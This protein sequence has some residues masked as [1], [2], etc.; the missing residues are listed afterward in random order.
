MSSLNA[1]RI[2]Q[3]VTWATTF[4]SAIPL[5]GDGSM[6][7]LGLCLSL[8]A[9]LA[10]PALAQA[11]GQETLLPDQQSR[12]TDSLIRGMQERIERIDSAGSIRK[13]E[14]E[15][16]NESINKAIQ[17][18]SSDYEDNVI[19]QQRTIELQGEINYLFSTQNELESNLRDA[20]SKREATVTKLG[21]EISDLTELLAHERNQTES[22]RLE[23]GKLSDQS[24]STIAENERLEENLSGASQAISAHKKPMELPRQAIESL[25]QDQAAIQKARTKLA[26][27]VTQLEQRLEVA[28]R[29]KVQEFSRYRSEFFG[30][31]REALGEHPDIRIA[32]DRFVFQSEVL[33][34]SST[35]ELD[36]AGQATLKS[37]ATTL[38]DVAKMIP[39]EVNWILRVDGHT[40]P[41]PISTSRFGSNWEL[42]SA[43]AISVVKFL[44]GQGVP[45]E[46]LAAAGFA[47]YQPL[48]LR[49]DEIAYRRNRRIEFRLT[50]R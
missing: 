21:S 28:L 14:I 26:K 20:A 27:K 16:L 19:L 32:G 15:V 9:S 10:T 34:A 31:L 48:D 12:E 38:Q 46:R 18:L 1:A 44:I 5:R 25:K 49:D 2:V 39:S 50:Q 45:P 6:K 36:P 30:R 43:R 3:T 22:L 4:Q 13:K 33:F 7:K 17:I 41:V 29:E 40:D 37:M 23:L 35:A 24:R 47:E 11:P 42:A 8:W